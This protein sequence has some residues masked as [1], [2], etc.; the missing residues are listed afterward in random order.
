MGKQQFFFQRRLKTTRFMLAK[1][2]NISLANTKIYRLHTFTAS[3]KMLGHKVFTIAFGAL[4]SVKA[5]FYPSHY[6]VEQ[7]TTEHTKNI[8]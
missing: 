4:A 2:I 5:K 8:G 3:E 6:F 7:L 1:L